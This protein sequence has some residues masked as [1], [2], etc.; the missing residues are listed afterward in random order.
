MSKR[1][2]VDHGVTFDGKDTCSLRFVKSVTFEVAMEDFDRG[3]W[4][5]DDAWNF[6]VGFFGAAIERKNTVVHL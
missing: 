2:L 5:R 3:V 4:V 6:L 1:T